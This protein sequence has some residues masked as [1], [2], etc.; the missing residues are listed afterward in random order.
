M[1]S[2]PLH[3]NA[4]SLPGFNWHLP[5]AIRFG[6]H[7]ADE[8]AQH[9]QGRRVMVMTFSGSRA[10]PVVDRFSRELADG[11]IDW[12]EIPDGLS[13]LALGRQV[14]RRAWPVLHDNPE[15]VV[16]GLGGGSVMDIAKWLRLRPASTDPRELD[17]LMESSVQPAGWLRHELWLMPTTAGTGSEVTCWSTLWD[18]D[19]QPPLKRSFDQP[20]AWADRAYVDPRL[21]LTCPMAVLRDS[22][23]DALGH[24]LEVLWNRHRNPVSVSLARQAATAVIRILPSALK[25]PDRLDLRSG[26]SMAALQAGLAFSQTRT[27][28]AH[29]LSYPLTVD[30]GVPH[31]AAV[32]LWLPLVWRMACGV[33]SDIDES[34]SA[35]M[36]LP[37]EL[38]SQALQRWL[39]E[40]G[41]G[42]SLHGLGVH[43]IK[44]RA[45]AA[46]EHPRGRNFEGRWIDGAV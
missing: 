7:A 42:L 4:E 21:S 20:Y 13:T 3:L 32:A 41:L 8:A 23:L 38:G 46:L 28:L 17:V 25:E 22:A 45:L 5:V 11:L 15:A 44:H 37:A 12:I 30:Q 18:T 19:T 10:G 29:A 14:A 40:V 2:S 35:V 6:T 43:D 9:L 16:V 26:L 33:K 24:A 27:A 39:G 31:G 1:A 36:G 34:L